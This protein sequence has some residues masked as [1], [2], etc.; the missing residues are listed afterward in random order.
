M[1]DARNL[2]KY[3]LEQQKV[4]KELIK[5]L[6]LKD[7]NLLNDIKDAGVL[8]RRQK[9]NREAYDRILD[10]QEIFEEVC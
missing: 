3:S 1:L 6:K 9:A 5:E 2:N 10:N 4:I 8:Y 7:P